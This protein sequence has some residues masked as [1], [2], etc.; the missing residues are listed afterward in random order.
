VRELLVA[1]LVA[2]GMPAA[3]GASTYGE[4]A[5]GRPL[6]VERAGDPAAAVRLLVVGSIHGNEP[7]GH[8]V[9][10][11]LRDTAPPPGVQ[12]WTVR[13]AN[14]DGVRESTRQN[15][16]GVDLNRNFPFRWAGGG[17]PF[18]TYYP[19]RAPASEPETRALQRLIADVRPHMTV[20]YHQQLRLVVLPRGAP[21]GPVRAYARRVGLPPRRLPAYR[22]TATSWQNHRAPGTTAFVVELPGGPLSRRSAARHARAVLAVGSRARAATAAPKPPIV[23]HPIPFGA[24][25]KRQMRRYSLRHY[26]EAKAKLVAPKVIVEH[27][28]ASSSFGSAYNTFAANARDVEFGE[29]P[30]VCAHY[31]IDRDGSIHQLVS[32]RWRCRHTVG[33]NHTAVG[34]EHVGIS[35]ADVMGN[36]RQLAASLRLTRW[37]QGRF[38]IPT[39]AV[40]G[41]A[42]S[43]SSPYHHERV[44][45]MRKRT[46]SDFGPA[47]MRRY[48][49]RL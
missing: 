28:T 8:A 33:L 4:S 46:H 45:A 31:L 21:L 22:G 6:R 12:L 11:R 3:A 35:D 32:L 39:R 10:A 27:Y 47:T 37:L 42:E 7:A 34:I 20:Y 14:P 30:G 36:R 26:G 5:E 2:L 25:R 49:G 43:L 15:G 17:R 19:G 1:L 24:E 38:G 9:I 40:I 18:D 48:R 23:W 13:A 16:R 41:H 44:A 29:L